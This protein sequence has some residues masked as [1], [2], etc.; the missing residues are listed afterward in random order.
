MAA[1][2]SPKGVRHASPH[3]RKIPIE[4][5]NTLIRNG[6]SGAVLGQILADTKPEAAYFTALNGQRSGI[7]V[8]N[9]NDPSDMPKLAEPF[10]LKLHATCEFQIAMTPEDLGRS[11]LDVLGQKWG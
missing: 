11:G 1:F 7:L 9:M 4:P 3:D 6:T 10:F 8:V 2:S 5:F